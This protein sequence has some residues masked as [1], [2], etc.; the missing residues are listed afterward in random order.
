MSPLVPP[1]VEDPL[2]REERRVCPG[3][4]GG[5]G[6]AAERGGEARDLLLGELARA[7]LGVDAGGEE[8]LGIE[9]VVLEK[10]KGKKKV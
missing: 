2:L 4:A 5:L 1:L 10:T 8:D 7:G 9:R 3:R 6:D